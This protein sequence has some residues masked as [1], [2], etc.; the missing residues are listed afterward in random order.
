MSTFLVVEDSITIRKLVELAFRGSSIDVDFATSGA[1][2]LAK[3]KASSPRVVLIDYVLPDMKGIEI[4][5]KVASG[6][7]PPPFVIVTSARMEEVKALF[8]PYSFVIDFVSKPFK[9]GDIVER[10]VAA[11]A[12][13]GSRFV[14]TASLRPPPSLLPSADREAAAFALFAQLRPRLA[15]IPTWA[16]ELG[17]TP[18]AKF[19]A[20]RILTPEVVDRLLESLLPVLR[21]RMRKTSPVA[22]EPVSDALLEGRIGTLSPYEILAVAQRLQRTGEVV[23]GAHGEIVTFLRDGK[24]V[25]ATSRN[26]AEWLK[27]LSI[28]LSG[29]PADA[30]RK[31]EEEQSATGKPVLVTLAELGCLPPCDLSGLLNEQGKRVLKRVLG[32]LGPGT[33]FAVRA[34]A[35][36]PLYVDAYGRGLSFRQ[37]VLERLR[38]DPHAAGELPAVSGDT[39]FERRG[40]FSKRLLQ[41]E[42]VP[43][44]RRVLA[45]IDGNATA[46]SIAE[47]TALGLQETSE[48]LQ[49]LEASELLGRRESAR[50][51][52][53]APPSV[54]QRQVVI[55]EPD[56][57]GFQRPLE[58]LL[59]E[60][61]GT[62]TLVPVDGEQD[63]FSAIKRARPALVIL[64]VSVH[65]VVESART[66]R[67][68]RGSDELRDLLLVAVLD[69]PSDDDTG[70]LSE[71][72]FDA[73]L[74]KPVCY[75]DIE[76]LLV[77]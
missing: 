20:R 50:A 1:E 10:V 44:E 74:S 36:L 27:D 46:R 7:G 40:G 48:A 59:A 68:V 58:R 17:D 73:V 45:L 42:L 66:A 62:Y 5:A 8:A 31:A 22:D 2:G 52:S 25:L 72:G 29:V 56:V 75:S 64:N 14:P 24:L 9:A 21:E 55:L 77:A 41:F 49:R 34:R 18:P 4:C 76:R 51:M 60:R 12:R 32:K 11:L 28:D 39:V 63:V 6:E 23:V 15:Q 53:E 54:V 67:A 3:I 47:R 35:T 33:P 71:A 13:D 38:D 37:V 30:M 65:G 43:S 16:G 57:E 26:P 70:P 61:P 19:Y 69:L